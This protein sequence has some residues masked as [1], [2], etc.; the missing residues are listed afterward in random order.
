MKKMFVILAA[1]LVAAFVLAAGF[2]ACDTGTSGG[3]STPTTPTRPTQYTITFN[4]NGGSGVTA[5][6]R[7]AGDSGDAACRP[8]ADG[9]YLQRVV[10]PVK[11]GKPLLVALHAERKRNDVRPVDGPV[12]PGLWRE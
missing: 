4:S 6:A 1:V 3:G 9:V 5:I 7:N 11:R 2:S 8:D 12:F 10:H